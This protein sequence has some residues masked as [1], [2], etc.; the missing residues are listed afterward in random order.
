M[1]PKGIEGGI[2][3]R[4]EIRML[5]CKVFRNQDRFSIYSN[6]KTTLSHSML[7][8]ILISRHALSVSDTCGPRY[9]Y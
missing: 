3:S 1:A 6:N 5:R 4:V 2:I 9:I 8:D 7:F